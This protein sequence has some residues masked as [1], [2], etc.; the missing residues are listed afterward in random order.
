MIQSNLI[1]SI[2]E[3]LNNGIQDNINIKLGSKPDQNIIFEE[4]V[5][6]IDNEKLERLT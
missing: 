3:R 4:P 1:A 5:I 6:Q 2:V